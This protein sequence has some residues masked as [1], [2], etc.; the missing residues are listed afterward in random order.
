[1]ARG[2]LERLIRSIGPP[3]AQT[4]ASAMEFLQHPR[5][6]AAACLVLD[7]RLLGQSGLDLQRE[8]AA[9][10]DAIPIIFITG[11]GDIP[12]SLRAMRAGAIEFLPKPVRDQDLLG[13]I[14]Q[15]IRLDQEARQHRSKLAQ[16][17]ICYVKLTL[18]EREVAQC[19]AKGLPNKQIGAELGISEITVKVYRHRIMKK[20]EARTIAELVHTIENPA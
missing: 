13:A 1:L 9:S 7:V 8:L 19:L 12:M 15:A 16:S 18:R 4:F 10:R 5:P 20:M 17:R 3:P 2:A 11:H 14:E 6:D